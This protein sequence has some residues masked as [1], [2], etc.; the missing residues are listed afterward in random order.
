M[1]YLIIHVQKNDHHRSHIHE[2]LVNVYFT[3]E[4]IEPLQGH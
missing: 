1:Q 3:D 2:I 4:D